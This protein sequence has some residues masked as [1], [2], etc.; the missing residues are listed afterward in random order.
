M[1]VEPREVEV[2]WGGFALVTRFNKPGNPTTR[3][4]ESWECWDE[5]AIAA[6]PNAGRRIAELRAEFGRALVGEF[7][8]GVPLSLLTKLIDAR[9]A[10]SVQV[11][12]DDAYAQRVEGQPNGK[13]ECW[14]V[15]EAEPDATIVLGW[16][17][18]TT[19]GEFL[20]RVKEGSLGELL[21]HVPV[22]P[23]DA[24]YLPAGTLHAIG[25][26]IVLFEAQQASDLTYRIYDYNRLGPDGKPR[27]L[28]LEK[29]ADVLDYH[30]GTAGALRPLRY[31]LD[32]LA[33]EALTADR[34]FVLERLQPGGEPHGYDLEGA[35]LAVMAL[36]GALELEAHGAVLRLEAYQT[37][38]VPA[39][40]EV[41]MLR[42]L[43]RGA[44]ALAAAPVHDRELM[45]RRLAR[46]G[47]GVN[48][49]TD[50][51]AQF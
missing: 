29:A 45:A 25:R 28:H 24:F 15:L 39:E 21:R 7:D 34:Y 42:R 51:L 3:I 48:A 16:N 27:P 20:E 37:A 36:G 31:E 41:V 12:P 8:P 50:F 2:I 14:Y 49:A 33:R 4:G 6:G 13:T 5:N 30:A 11:H 1:L 46:A 22:Q 44:A 38:L 32:G 23:G 43:E 18:D 19:R 35:P 26:G 47:V 40:S 9:H 10:L 17:R